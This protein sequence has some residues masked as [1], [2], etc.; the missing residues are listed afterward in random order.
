MTAA[1]EGIRI[2]DFTQVLAG[3]FAV[4][5]MA[6]LG[7]DVIK[8]E[9][10]QT[11]D[12]TRGLMNA[13]EDLQMSP[14][15]MGMN[16][17]KRSLTLNLKD[18]HAAEI[19]K[20]LLPTVDVIVENFKA[21]TM[22]RRGLD[23][24]S[25]RALKPDLIYCSITGYGQNGPKAGDAAY[26]GAIQASSGM[27]SQNGHPETGPTRTG[28]MPVDMSTALNSAF[29][30]SAALYRKA[31]TGEGQHIDVAMLDTA[32]IMQAPQFSNF[33]NQGS[34]I[35]LCGNASPTRQP[36]ANVF[37]TMDGHIQITAL[38]Q[39]QVEKLFAELDL[40]KMLEDERFAT[41]DSRINHPEAIFDAMSQAL[42]QKTTQ[43]WMKQLAPVGIPVA[44][45]RELPEV[46]S[47]P[48]ISHRN[49]LVTVPSPLDP[50]ATVT[51][52]KAGYV[53][54]VDGPEVRSGPPVLGA[55]TDDILA[56]LGYEPKEIERLKNT[57]VI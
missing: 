9:Q 47:D 3:P 26:D 50:D 2:L 35:G 45:V 38:R 37:P 5:Q 42:N 20:K 57:G 4:M 16:L 19:I 56:G 48:D 6:L 1:F 33:L 25:L 41:P 8:V 17:N 13:G 34:L 54:N 27:M 14:S 28:Y 7:A 55:D 22:Q 44:E 36:T 43:V 39:P 52:A 51:V 31:T 24:E 11:G 40:E 18:E 21:G 10:P 29:A 46:A 32:I 49:A 30:I 15:F 12:Q 53:T 23:Y